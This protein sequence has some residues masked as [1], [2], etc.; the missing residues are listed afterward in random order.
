[1]AMLARLAEIVG[2]NLPGALAA[3]GALYG[4]TEDGGVTAVVTTLEIIFTSQT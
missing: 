3:A 4:T 1:M 2:V